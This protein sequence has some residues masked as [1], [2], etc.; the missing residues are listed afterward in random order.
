MDLQS[1]TAT[2]GVGGKLVRMAALM[3]FAVTGGILLASHAGQTKSSSTVVDPGM[4]T[5]SIASR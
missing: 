1:A 2:V 4:T 3:C 5:S